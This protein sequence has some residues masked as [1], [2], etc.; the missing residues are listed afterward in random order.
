M[1]LNAY[2]TEYSWLSNCIVLNLTCQTLAQS[3]TQEIDES[4]VKGFNF[5]E[6]FYCILIEEQHFAIIYG[7]FQL[8][9]SVF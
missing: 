4:L 3:M 2:W 5:L 1:N 7:V 9:S 6:E 8:S